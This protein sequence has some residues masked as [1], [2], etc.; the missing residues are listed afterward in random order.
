MISGYKPSTYRTIEQCPILGKREWLVE[1][2]TACDGEGVCIL[3]G[4]HCGDT[5]YPPCSD[6]EGVGQTGKFRQIG[7]DGSTGPWEAEE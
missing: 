7:S 1:C 5:G 4:A 3:P 6:C 2:C